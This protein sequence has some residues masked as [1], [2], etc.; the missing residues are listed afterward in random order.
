MAITED[1]TKLTTFKAYLKQIGQIPSYHLDKCITC[2]LPAAWL[3]MRSIGLENVYFDILK[4][5]KERSLWFKELFYLLLF[6]NKDN[7]FFP[8][9]PDNILNLDIPPEFI[10]A[11]VEMPAPEFQLAYS[12]TRQQLKETL[13]T[14]AQPGR[15][16]RLGDKTKAI[17]MMKDDNG[18]FAIYHAGNSQ[19]LEYKSIDKC[20]DLI[21][22]T[23]NG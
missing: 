23:I 10:D 13:E 11:Q 18:S 9:L 16:I 14:L 5:V 6:T 19:A 8:H 17:G 3:Y 1:I 20:V 4:K 21:M 12:F 2:G 22:R 15:M 7:P